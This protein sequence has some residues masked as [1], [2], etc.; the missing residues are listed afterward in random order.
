MRDERVDVVVRRFGAHREAQR[1]AR[2]FGRDAHGREHVAAGLAAPLEQ[3]AAA[4]A[5]TPS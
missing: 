5:Q 2:S 3:L 1:A 4:D